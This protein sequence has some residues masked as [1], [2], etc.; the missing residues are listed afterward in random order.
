VRTHLVLTPDRNKEGRS[1][2]RGAFKPEG[3]RYAAYWRAQGDTV[4][5][6]RIDVSKGH[7]ERRQAVLARIEASA[8]IDV[9][10]LLCH[11]WKEGVQLGLSIERR[12]EREAFAEFARRLA[13]ASAPPLYVVLYCCLTGDSDEGPQ[14]DGGF[15]DTLRDALCAAGRPD[16]HVFA[17]TTA[18]HTTRNA[19]VRLFRGDGSSTGGTGGVD[20]VARGTAA[21]RR[22][23]E[24]LHDVDD[25]LRWRIPFLTPDAILAELA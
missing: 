14:G 15:A 12:D 3:E 25:P 23:D 20:P 4:Q 21:F 22:L 13:A 8:P 7:R 1:D 11:G 2:F 9:L 16:V 19:R 5:V 6:H 18:G 10:T 24:R 17:H